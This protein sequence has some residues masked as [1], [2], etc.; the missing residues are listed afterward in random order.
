MRTSTTFVTQSKTWR[1]PKH[2]QTGGFHAKKW[3][4]NANLAEDSNL[5]E[6]VLGSEAETERVFGIVWLPDDDMLTFKIKMV[7][8]PDATQSDNRKTPTPLRLTKRTLL[9]KLVGIFDPTGAATAVLIKLKVAMQELWQL[10]LEWDQEVPT[11][12]KKKMA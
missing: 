7:I 6:V 11:E 4:S 5:E 3:T 9:S 2:R 8:S 1:K 12:A 10:G